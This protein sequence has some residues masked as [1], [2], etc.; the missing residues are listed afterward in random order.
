[1]NIYEHCPEIENERFW[2]RLVAER[3]CGDLRNVYSDEASVP[4]FNSD[5]CSGD[6]FHYSTDERMIEA[7]RF[8]LWSY[9]QGYFVRWSILDKAAECAV[10]TIELFRRS[11][12][13]SYNGCGI[14]RLDLRSDYEQEADITEILALILL[15]SFAWFDCGIIVTK[16]KPIARARVKALTQMGFVPACQPLIGHDGTA[17][18]DYYTLRKPD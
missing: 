8:W 14:L 4:L 18:G 10:G 13:D 15:P 12:Q 3:D 1:M 5:N 16:A 6:D 9:R 17:Y 7:I 11:S 2:L